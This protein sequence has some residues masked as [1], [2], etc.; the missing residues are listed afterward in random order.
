MVP[1]EVKLKDGSEQEVEGWITMK[2]DKGVE[3]VR[4]VGAE[5][6]EDGSAEEERADEDEEQADEEEEDEEEEEEEDEEQEQ[7]Q[8]EEEEAGGNKRWKARRRSRHA[9]VLISCDFL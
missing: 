8:D 3:F 2:N 7:E 5:A 1:K 4:Q 6:G 9:H